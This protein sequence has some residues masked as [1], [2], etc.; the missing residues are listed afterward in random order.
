MFKQVVD[1]AQAVYDN[2]DATQEEVDAAAVKLE[3]AQKALVNK[4]DKTAL[5]SAIAEA[6]KV[7]ADKY[8]KETVD[9][10]NKALDA[11]KKVD[12]DDN[13]TQSEADA[14]LKAL[15]EA[16]KG[17]KA[18]E[19]NPTPNPTPSV[20]KSQLKAAVDAADALQKGS[21][22]DASWKA[23]T[24]A[25]NKAKDVLN[26]DDATQQDVDAALKA[27]QEA[28]KNMGVAPAP[29]TP[30]APVTSDPGASIASTGSSITGIAVAVVAAMILGVTFLLIN[31]SRR[32][33]R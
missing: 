27:L 24:D 14:A 23:F 7:D 28:Q 9:A 4:A 17:L 13:A 11:A 5:E 8:T 10:L 16:I 12:A 2:A 20:D 26:D 21:A 6:E 33:D 3:E 22:S 15:N 18:K 32:D 19:E 1:E 31:R 29:T 25:L 30:A